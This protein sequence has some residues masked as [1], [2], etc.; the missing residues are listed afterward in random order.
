MDHENP[1]GAFVA[2]SVRVIDA[3]APAPSQLSALRRTPTAEDQRLSTSIEAERPPSYRARLLAGLESPGQSSA[4]SLAEASAR[5]RT[6]AGGDPVVFAGGELVAA[7]IRRL[8]AGV[9]DQF[10]DLEELL[11]LFHP[12]LPAGDL[13]ARARLL[14]MTPGEIGPAGGEEDTIA[15]I[16]QALARDAQLLDPRILGEI[17]QRSAGTSW[18]L[19]RFFAAVVSGSAREP[20][21]LGA[22]LFVPRSSLTESPAAP[23]MRSRRSSDGSG[24]VE[25]LERATADGRAG[26]EP[27]PEQIEMATAVT[28][29]LEGEYHL[30]VEAGTGTG[31]SLAYLLPAASRALRAD[32][33]VVISTNTIN[34][35]EQLTQKDIPAVRSLLG[36]YGPADLQERAEQLRGVSLKG[37][38]NYLCLQRLAALRRT[39][40]L[41]DVEARFLVRVLIWLSRGGGD[42]SGLRLIPEEELLWSRVSAEGTTCFASGGP[43]VRNGS[44]QLLQ[45]RRRAE[46]AHLVVVNH[47]LLLSD[48]AADQHILPSYDRLIVDEAHNLEDIATDQFGFHAGQGEVNTLLDAVL[49]RGRERQA[50]LVVDVRAATRFASEAADRQHLELVLQDLIDRIDRARTLAPETFGVLVGF[51]HAHGAADGEYD[52]R[53]LLTRGIRAQPEWTQVELTWE[54]LRLALLQIESGLERLGVALAERAADTV[55]DR[56]ALLGSVAGQ[57]LATRLLREGM[58]SV[59]NR[60]DDQRIAWLTVNRATGAVTI[61]SAPLNVGDLLHRDLFERRSSVIL[62]SATLSTNGT[63]A[64]VRDRLGLT[65]A[66]EL[67]LGS[68][69]DYQ[70]AALLLLPVDMPE[71]SSPGYQQALENATVEL[72]LASEGRALMLFTSHAAL[73]TTYRAVRPRLTAG[74][75]R[76][77][78]QGIDGTPQD[79]LKALRAQGRTVVLGTSSFW[80]GVDVVGDALS[81]LIIAKL[82]FSV[83]SDPVFAARS[84]LF[85]EPFRDYALPQA[86][87]RFKQGFGRLIRQRGDRGVVA[88]LDRRLRSKSYGR[89]FLRSLP[90]CTVRDVRVAASASVVR[91]WLGGAATQRAG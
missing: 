19:R 69:F 88:V 35:Q 77:L 55:L 58:E 79:L 52:R 73:R 75:V 38:R 72:C 22:A 71:P 11:D 91:D 27:R 30:V 14:G 4:L 37:R 54:N 17:V 15:M 7:A 59:L 46:A 81:M 42:R 84:E 86:V 49:V 82:P 48:L 68:P 80:E 24:V 12:D 45:A 26:Y 60:H 25:T 23:Q 2:L 3:E 57:T 78:A 56:E 44:C 32:E 36:Q 39:P 34:L 41:T 47:A 85:D 9:D 31:K 70:R 43:F 76:V 87:L 40:I 18:P 63:F 53:V 89:V 74:G 33:R 83:P 10:L 1:F 8:L 13:T 21:P 65:E 16:F 5:L 51:A 20:D 64:Y 67:A 66:E 62:T 29:A 61:A 90:E 6:L 28:Q 50:G